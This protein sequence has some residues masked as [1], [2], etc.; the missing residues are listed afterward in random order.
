MST[1]N[2]YILVSNTILQKKEIRTPYEVVDS[3][4]EANNR[5]DEPGAYSNARK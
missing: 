3:R 1:P 2:V 4:A 5:Q